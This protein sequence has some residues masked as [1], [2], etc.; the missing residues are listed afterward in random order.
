[1]AQRE[2]FAGTIAE[3]APSDPSGLPSQIAFRNGARATLP[4]DQPADELRTTLE[5]LRSLDWPALVAVETTDANDRVIQWVDIP[6]VGRVEAITSHAEGHLIKFDRSSTRHLLKTGTPGSDAL[7]DLFSRSRNESRLLVVSADPRTHDIVNATEAEEIVYRDNPPMLPRADDEPLDEDVL[8]L[9]TPMPPAAASQ[10]VRQMDTVGSCGMPGSNANCVPFRYPDGGCFARAHR[11]CELLEHDGIVAGKIWIYGDALAAQTADHPDC[12]VS[13]TWHVAV[14]VKSAETGR[15]L[16]LDP[17]LFDAAVEVSTFVNSLRDRSARVAITTMAP[18]IR[19]EDGRFI[20][21]G[22]VRSR[23]IDETE[24]Y[25]R[26]YR[27]RLATRRPPPP[28]QCAI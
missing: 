1:M 27:R 23:G 13:W 22:A 3:I 10:F 18:F 5:L 12:S 8:E 15:P 21:E 9:L 16:V 26:I 28:Y 2:L 25:L 24:A 11:M 4:V 19:G 17:A 7:F 20:P 6:V 14:V